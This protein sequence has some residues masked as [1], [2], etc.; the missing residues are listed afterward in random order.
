M[1][2]PPGGPRG[3]TPPPYPSKG[4]DI[5]ILA[6][7]FKYMRQNSNIWHQ[8]QTK[9]IFIPPKTS[10]FERENLLICHPCSSPSMI[11]GKKKCKKKKCPDSSPTLP[12]ID[13][14]RK[15]TCPPLCYI[16]SK[17]PLE[18]AQITV[19]KHRRSISYQK[20]RVFYQKS[21]T[22]NQ[23]SPVFCQKSPIFSSNIIMWV[24]EGDMHRPL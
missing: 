3:P 5:T 23:K 8:I 9:W 12:S 4:P 22:F 19:K 14:S 20:S 21:P 2:K 7:K 18:W 24:L 15:I 16:L 11:V 17:D 10:L 13:D 6:A 1:Q